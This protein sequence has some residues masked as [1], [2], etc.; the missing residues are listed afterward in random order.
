MPSALLWQA[1]LARLYKDLESVI[2]DEIECGV[3]GDGGPIPEKVRRDCIFI[4][5]RWH[6]QIFII[7]MLYII[8][9][10]L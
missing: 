1:N 3:S 6:V 5:Q 7:L 9:V 8:N 10:L 2:T 4:A